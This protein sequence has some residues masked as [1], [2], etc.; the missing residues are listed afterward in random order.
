LG[1]LLPLTGT[2]FVTGTESRA[3]TR[4]LH[5]PDIAKPDNHQAFTVCFAMD[6]VPGE[7]HTIEKPRDYDFWKN[8]VPDLTPPWPGKL[9]DLTYTHPSTLQTQ[10]AWVQPGRIRRPV[11]VQSME[12]SPDN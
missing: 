3:E 5:A 12:L 10:G 11:K 8:H 4:E 2:E 7:D 1:D 6:Y 9:L